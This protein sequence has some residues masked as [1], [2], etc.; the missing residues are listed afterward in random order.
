MY[1]KEEVDKIYKQ[2]RLPSSYLIEGE[3]PE[4]ALLRVMRDQLGIEEFSASAPLVMSYNS[5]SDWYPG[6]S[7]W[8]LV[9]LYAV[10]TSASPKRSPWW[11]E[12]AFLSK[13]EFRRKDLGWNE[14]MM[15]D[16]GLV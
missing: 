5:P 15:K 11:H 9:F 8:D 4:Q 3:H 1:S 10:K 2:T 12:L 7:H 16:L 14:D 13:R 6:K